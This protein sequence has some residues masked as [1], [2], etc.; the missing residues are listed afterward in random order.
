MPPSR[1]LALNKK[2]LL[3]TNGGCDPTCL[4]TDKPNTAARDEILEF[5]RRRFES[6]SVV[7]GESASRCRL[8]EGRF[9]ERS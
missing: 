2:D 6:L 8:T 7:V 4:L 1:W 5:F 3:P 9:N